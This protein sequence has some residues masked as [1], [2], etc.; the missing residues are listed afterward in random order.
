LR[1][2]DGLYAYQLAV[3]VDDEAQK[4]TEVVRGID[5]LDSTVRQIFLQ[6]MLNYHEPAYMHLPI[7]VNS[8]GDKLSKRTGACGLDAS[9]PSLI[10]MEALD[11]LGHRPPAGSRGSA[12]AE[13]LDW[14]IGHWRPGRL[15]GVKDK[16]WDDSKVL[17]APQ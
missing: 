13:L 10:T 5:L 17:A 7:A 15:S 11:F 3:V 4:I 2:G 8:A 6:Q 9:D 12:P 16:L 14:A 1:R